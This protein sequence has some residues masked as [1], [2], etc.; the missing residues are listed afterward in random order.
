MTNTTCDL[1]PVDS[2]GRRVH[3]ALRRF[4]PAGAPAVLCVHGLT[5]HGHDF[6]ALAAGLADRC[7]VLLPDLPGR[8]DS[9]WCAPGQAYDDRLYLDTLEAV[10]RQQQVDSVHWVGTSLGAQLGLRMNARRPGLLASLVMNDSG[11]QVDGAVLRALRENARQRTA[12]AD[13][14]E[15]RRSLRLRYAEFGIPHEAEWQHFAQHAFVQEADG[16]WRL[17]FD[18]R[19]VSQA[20]VPDV[21]DLWP[22]WHEV[23][24]PALI[25]RGEHSRVLPREVADRMV[26]EV[27]DARVVEIAGA[28]HAPHLAG[29]ARIRL[30]ADFIQRAESARPST[31]TP[32]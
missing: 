12:H 28:G 30:L 4:G 9:E 19:V 7:Q 18:P 15:A 27:P 31:R 10:L 20:S 16:L 29:E 32:A 6:D 5:R 22:L 13:L 21:V 1:V 3:V 25:V 8:G 11:A 14:A 17:R 24:C 23:R 26:R 2:D